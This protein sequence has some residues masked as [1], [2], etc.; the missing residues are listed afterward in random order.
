[1]TVGIAQAWE[2]NTTLGSQNI[3]AGSNALNHWEPDPGSH[4]PESQPEM[5]LKCWRPTPRSHAIWG[6]QL[7]RP[8]VQQPIT[9]KVIGWHI[10]SVLCRCPS[11]TPP[12]L[13][14]VLQ[15]T[16]LLR[17]H[18]LASCQQSLATLIVRK[19]PCHFIHSSLQPT[20]SKWQALCEAI[21]IQR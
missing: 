8:T 5:G 6:S 14:M 17:T 4:E 10:F 12:I 21:R 3:P 2:Q 11:L 7:P 18:L 15:H 13:M 19:Y 20:F 9:T 16:I 1:M